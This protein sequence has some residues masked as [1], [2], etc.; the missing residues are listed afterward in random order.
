MTAPSATIYD[1]WFSNTIIQDNPPDSTDYGHRLRH[2][3]G[4]DAEPVPGGT[5]GRRAGQL[6]ACEWLC[7]STSMATGKRHH[8]Q[9]RPS[10]GSG[11]S[12][13]RLVWYRNIRTEDD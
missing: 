12:D 8:R 5:G 13:D 3:S 2:Q 10:P 7:S 11:L 9:S 4:G 1:P 6:H